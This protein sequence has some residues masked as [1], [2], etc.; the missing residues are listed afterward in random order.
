MH[1]RCLAEKRAEPGRR[2]GAKNERPLSDL[3]RSE[4]SADLLPG[5]IRP[6]SV[7]QSPH[8]YAKYR[9][10]GQRQSASD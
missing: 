7:E 3:R 8:A 9:R 6:E 10:V 2:T 5:Q 1:E 4:A